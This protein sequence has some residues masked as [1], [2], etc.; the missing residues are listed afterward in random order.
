MA[1]KTIVMAE[2]N[3]CDRALFQPEGL[4]VFSMQEALR[5]RRSAGELTAVPCF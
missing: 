4:Y 1:E 5:F 3:L 2:M